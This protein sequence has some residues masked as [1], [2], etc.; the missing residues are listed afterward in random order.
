MS[1]ALV[2][3]TIQSVETPAIV[4]LSEGCRKNNW[5]FVVAG[6]VKSPSDFTLPFGD[7]L[8]IK[9]QEALSFELSLQL[10]YHHYSRKNLA[11]LHAIK[12]GATC[13]VETD[14]DNLPKPEFWKV[15][16]SD[17][18]GR[19]IGTK[20]W[21]NAYSY[22]SQASLWPRGFSLRHLDETQESAVSNQ[23]TV[24]CPIQQYLADGDP[25]IDAIQRLQ[26]NHNITF[27]R[28]DALILN[29]G[30]VCPFNSQN[31]IWFAEAFAL[32]YLPSTCSFRMC[33]IWRSFVA[34]RV[35]AETNWRLSFHSASVEQVRNA[36]DLLKD[37]EEEAVGYVYNTQLFE[38]L[39]A[40]KLEQGAE[41]IEKNL[42]RCY[43]Y[44]IAKNYLDASE[45]LLLEAWLSDLKEC[46]KT[47][48]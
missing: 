44:M 15:A 21:V 8:S 48:D 28:A 20:R 4:V 45:M 32:L 2:L 19:H 9:T 26:S 34:Q 13:I 27:E 24:F 39:W 6:D 31:T 29:A 42:K 1:T 33:D 12:N 17:I 38:E 40:L 47:H 22:F 11:Y 23:E 5:L 25:D 30:S 43:S 7:Y 10:P 41:A 35:M 36:H 16:S 14:D 46:R 18:K 37:L 3:T